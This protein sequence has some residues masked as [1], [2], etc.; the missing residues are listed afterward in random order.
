MVLEFT[1]AA[2]PSGPP[3]NVRPMVETGSDR[4]IR[5]GRVGVAAGGR[6]LAHADGTPFFYLADTAWN[7]VLLSSEPDWKTYLADRAAKGFTAIQFIIMA[8]WAAAYIDAEGRTAF[9]ADDPAK[10]NPE[11]F[12]RIDARIQAINDAG[13][14]AVPVLAWAAKFGDSAR[15]NPGV[16]LGANHLES[17]V[18][19]QVDRYA[20]HHVLWLLAGDGNY[21]GWRSWKW[22]RI[23]RSVFGRRTEPRIP[24]GLH[25]MGMTWPYG[26][27]CREP[28]LD[29]LGYQS[30]H[31]TDPRTLRWLLTGAPA[32]KW[33]TDARPILNLEPCYE[34][35]HN[36][37]V[38]QAMTNVEVRRAMYA[39]LLNAPTAGVSYGA[40]GVWSWETQPRE[41]LN[42]SGT[43][44]ARPWHEAMQFPGSFDV[45]R[46]AS[47]FLSIDWWR[48]RP[49]QALL[50]A[51]PGTGDPNR[52]I[53]IAATPER[54]LAL[55]Y[56]PRGGEIMLDFADGMAFSG[57]WFDPRTG[58]R[59]RAESHSNRTFSAPDDEDWALLLRRISV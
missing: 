49:A 9:A 23:G 45:R 52:F 18:R 24:V 29:L 1:K 51:Q 44:V 5:H 11:F 43:G 20:K 16:S 33:Q 26:S 58:E 40:H 47:L 2:R 6:H 46:I 4:W 22:K 39:S 21:G 38:N 53:S 50:R 32:K 35:I 34:G 36:G 57:E 7:G 56:L 12:H 3:L 42:H 48:L 10:I 13:L 59:C 15:H 19:F 41:P 37:A 14:L 28:W 17:L 8:P 25:P 30:S 55:A 27:F 54:D 31:S